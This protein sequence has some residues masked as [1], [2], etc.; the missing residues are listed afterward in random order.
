MEQKIA[1]RS[2]W[3][4]RYKG[5]IIL[6][7]KYYLHFEHPDLGRDSGRSCRAFQRVASPMS[8]AL[9]KPTHIVSP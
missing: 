1:Y 8:G 4:Q 9:G 3:E 7:L 2:A 6:V 5:S